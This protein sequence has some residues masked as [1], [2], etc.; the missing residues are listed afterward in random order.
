MKLADFVMKAVNAALIDQLRNRLGPK[1]VTTNPD[2]IAPWLTDWR[3][4]YHGAS[5]ALL[6]PA[7]TQEVA[8]TVRMAALAG[9]SLV[10]Q[11]G[12]TSMVGGATPMPDGKA[13]ILSL[14]RMNAIRHI[15][16]GAASIV[17]EAG[18]IL[19]HLHDS[20]LAAGLR[21]PL[22]LGGKGSAT[23]GGLVSTNAGGT[24]VLRFGTMR[25]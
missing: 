12:N 15:D 5:S 1:G 3:N 25:N 8:D 9:V 20:A 23:I 2:D 18:V 22:T 17:A 4:L 10:P 13:L 11:G 16:A 19:A 21:F 7:T 14:R 6:S 24:Q